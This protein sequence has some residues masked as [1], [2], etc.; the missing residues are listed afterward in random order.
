MIQVS[1]LDDEP[2]RFSSAHTSDLIVTHMNNSFE[3]EEEEMALKE[4]GLA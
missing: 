3:E 2:D 4:E 1:D